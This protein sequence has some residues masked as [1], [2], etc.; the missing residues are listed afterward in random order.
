M[1]SAKIPSVLK[2]FIC[3]E[4]VALKP[5]GP[6]ILTLHATL[7]SRFPRFLVQMVLITSTF[8]LLL[9]MKCS[10]SSGIIQENDILKS[11]FLVKTKY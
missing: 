9:N 5:G 4:E 7:H 2:I 6:A 3:S 11:K 10:N 8:L 1:T